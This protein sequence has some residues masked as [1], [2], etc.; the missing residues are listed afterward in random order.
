MTEEEKLRLLSSD[1]MLIKRPL[2]VDK[3]FIL[4]GFKIKEYQE[5]F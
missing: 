2:L 3:E 5:K 4:I 1:G